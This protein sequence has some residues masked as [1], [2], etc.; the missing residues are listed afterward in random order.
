VF[1]SIPW[2]ALK[3]FQDHTKNDRA[4]Q[5]AEMPLIH[6]IEATETTK[7]SRTPD[8]AAPRRDQ[9]FLVHKSIVTAFLLQQQTEKTSDARRTFPGPN[10][11][12][13]ISV[14]NSSVSGIAIGK[15]AKPRHRRVERGT[16]SLAISNP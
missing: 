14:A 8:R 9:A 11:R 12:R 10:P 13:R 15:G 7:S 4:S 1:A 2:R 16:D 5:S 3:K 6:V